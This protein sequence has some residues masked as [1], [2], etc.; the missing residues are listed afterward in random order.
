MRVGNDSVKGNVMRE[1]SRAK[2]FAGV[3]PFHTISLK[4]AGRLGSLVL[5]S[6]ITYG[7]G[8]RDRPTILVKRL[9]ISC[10]VSC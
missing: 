2:H 6:L 8:R 4:D 5:L 9:Y 7:I 3:Q 10:I 1:H